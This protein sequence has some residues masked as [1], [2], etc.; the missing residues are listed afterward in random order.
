MLTTL[1]LPLLISQAPAKK[2]KDPEARWN[3]TVAAIEKRLKGQTFPEGGVMFAGA[4][5]VTR[6]KL[7]ADFPGRGYANAG[8]GG[9]KIAESV[10]FAPRLEGAF[11]P[12]QVVFISGGNDLASGLTPEQVQK[13]FAAYVAAV[14]K[15]APSCRILFVSIRPT[16]KRESQWGTQRQANK[17]VREYCATDPALTYLDVTADMLGPDGK[18]S[19]RCWW[20]TCSTP[21]AP[22]TRCWRRG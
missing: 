5:A 12:G 4:S 11:K 13:D 1:L 7:E 21:A 2:A 18:P 16:I 20:T 8:F 17:L 3:D 14:R 9:S 6:W 15:A 10:H 19:A 22:V